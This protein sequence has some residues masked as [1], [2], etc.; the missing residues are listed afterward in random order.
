MLL[1]AAEFRIDSKIVELV[2]EQRENITG[3]ALEVEAQSWLARSSDYEVGIGVD[4]EIAASAAHRAA[5]VAAEIVDADW[6]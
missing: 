3:A 4:I 1:I 2:F 5:A 6:L